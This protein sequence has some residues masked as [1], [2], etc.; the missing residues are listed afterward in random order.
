MATPYVLD[1]F[2]ISLQDV[3]RVRGKNASLGELFRALTPMGIGALD[4][5]ATMADAYRLLLATNDLEA[6]LS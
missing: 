6:R 1:F 5:F 4:G 3:P 2:Q